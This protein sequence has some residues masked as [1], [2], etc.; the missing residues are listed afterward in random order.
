MVLHDATMLYLKE[1]AAQ[2]H[3][4]LKTVVN[5]TINIG[6]GRNLQAKPHWKC[7]SHDMGSGFDYTKAWEQIDNLEAD[8]VAEKIEIRK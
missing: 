5:E 8:A 1:I 3:K 2:Q 4:T 6:L 7:E